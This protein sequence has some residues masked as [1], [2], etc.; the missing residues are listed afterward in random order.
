M[1]NKALFEWSWDVRPATDEEY[2]RMM[3]SLDEH[4]A[5]LKLGPAQRPLTAVLMVS[6][7]LGLSGTPILGGSDDRGEPFSPQDLLARVH[8]WYEETYGEKIKVDFSPGSIVISLHGNLWEMKMPKVLGSVQMF[9]S[10]DLSNKGNSIITK[11]S[12]PI[13]HNI[14]CSVQGMTQAYADRLSNDEMR[15]LVEKFITGS[16]AVLCLD[17]LQGHDLFNEAR[18]DYRH[19]VD[20]LLTGHE[21]SKARWDTAQCAE[22]ILKGLLAR[23]GHAYPTFGAQG[24]DINYLGG[25]T[26]EKLGIELP[27]TELTMIYCSSSVRYGQEKCTIDRA[28]AAHDALVQLLSLLAKT[29]AHHTHWPSM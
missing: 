2:D 20:A 28:L 9:I 15:L 17:D 8:T 25:L 4:L 13:Q 11:K 22:K 1:D 23:N 12:L 29:R 3:T 16:E 21:L 6:S 10:A 18:G 24:H 26:K 27:A 14:L 7:T 19:S 5:S